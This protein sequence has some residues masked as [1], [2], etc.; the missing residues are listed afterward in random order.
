VRRQRILW[1]EWVTAGSAILLITAATLFWPVLI[2]QITG[3]PSGY[4]D[5][6]LGW[7]RQYLGRVIFVPFTPFYLLYG[8]LWG[9]FGYALVTVVLAA[10]IFWLTRPSTRG[11]GVDIWT[12]SVMYIA[13]LVAV[14]LP[15]QSLIRMLLPLSPLLGHPGLSATP[16]R[17]WIVL[18]VG[19]LPLQAFSVFWLWVVYPP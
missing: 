9:W 8:M 11:L 18:L 15:T 2:A 6:E 16:R 12:Y 1:H 4:F 5:T 17:R 14:F 13:Y 10:V 7:W 19:A 3:D